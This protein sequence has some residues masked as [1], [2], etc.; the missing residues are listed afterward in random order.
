METAAALRYRLCILL[1]MPCELIANDVD[2][3]V[4]GYIEGYVRR[5]WQVGTRLRT[6]GM[7][8]TREDEAK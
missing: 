8:P 5:F 6:D 7:I 4:P 2:Q 3:R 1:A